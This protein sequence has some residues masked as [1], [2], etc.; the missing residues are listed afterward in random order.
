MAEGWV[1]RDEP[2]LIGL[3]S[4]Q[5]GRTVMWESPQLLPGEHTFHLRVS[6]KPNP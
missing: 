4:P 1:D 5:R 2:T 6:Q 3:Y